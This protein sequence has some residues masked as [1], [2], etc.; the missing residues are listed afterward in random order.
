MKILSKR[1][2]ENLKGVHPNLVKLMEESIKNSP[3][4]FT[5][6]EGIRTVE[7][8]KE[9]YA[10]GRTKKGPIVTTKD[11]VKN[12]S[13]HQTKADGFGYAVDL[14]PN[15][16]GKVQVVDKDTVPNLKKIAAHIKI[17]AK[18]L[19]IN[20]TW[21]GDWKTPYDPPHFELK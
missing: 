6:T 3:I 18:E 15:I 13:N 11:G 21:G 16:N 10:Q 4:D 8:Q 7:E 9:L 19:N 12:K 5:I 17:V 14:Y 2:Q 1:S 20:I